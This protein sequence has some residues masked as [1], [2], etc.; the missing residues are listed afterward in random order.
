M[1]STNYGFQSFQG[2]STCTWH[3]GAWWHLHRGESIVGANYHVSPLQDFSAHAMSLKVSNFILKKYT[4]LLLGWFSCTLHSQYGRTL[5][6][7]KRRK[8]TEQCLAG[9]SKLEW[10]KIEGLPCYIGCTASCRKTLILNIRRNKHL[11]GPRQIAW[12]IHW[13]VDCCKILIILIQL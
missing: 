10:T 8:I 5:I 6:N 2:S 1:V 9:L 13:K 11:V 3:L 12:L 7:V 4:N